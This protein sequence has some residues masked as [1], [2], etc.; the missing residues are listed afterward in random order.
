MD[1]SNLAA[2]DIADTLD[3]I[4]SLDDRSSGIVKNAVL[5]WPQLCPYY[6]FFFVK[7]STTL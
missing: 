7:V 6:R 5:M 1:S 4:K 3:K 2:Y